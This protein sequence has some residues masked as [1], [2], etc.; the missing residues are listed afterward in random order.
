ML[1]RGTPRRSSDGTTACSGVMIGVDISVITPQWA[2]AST[3][4][5]AAL[6]PSM[7]TFPRG[8]VSRNQMTG[9]VII[10]PPSPSPSLV[11]RSGR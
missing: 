8:C 1:S 7:M 4:T 3:A 9:V 6:P 5:S 11:F 2:F 10:S